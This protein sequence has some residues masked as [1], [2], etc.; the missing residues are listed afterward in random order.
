MGKEIALMRER[1]WAQGK[2]GEEREPG[3]RVSETD[4][5]GWVKDGGGNE[6]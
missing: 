5:G 3:H 4:T 1:K 2:S 6:L